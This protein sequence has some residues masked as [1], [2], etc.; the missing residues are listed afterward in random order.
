MTAARNELLNCLA[1][2]S[3]AAPDLRLG[4]MVANIATLARGAVPEAVWDAED[5]ELVAAARSLVED[6]RARETSVA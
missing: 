3:E 1:E 6:Y 4:Q 2:L 5:E